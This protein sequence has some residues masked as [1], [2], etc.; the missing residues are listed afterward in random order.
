MNLTPRTQQE[1][2]TVYAAFIFAWFA[3]L[4]ILHEM[5]L[6][7]HDIAPWVWIV[8]V[9]AAISAIAAGYVIR[10]KFFKLSNQVL[11]SDPGK[12]R[13][14]WRAANLI[15]LNSALSVTFYGAV[16]KLLGSGWLV[17]GIFFGVSLGLLV[18]WRPRELDVAPSLT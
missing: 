16:L 15:G 3:I 2:K 8:V 12:A 11:G 6:S 9:A 17:P 7:R 14:H 5:N 1:I 4:F 18:L 10:K 13:G